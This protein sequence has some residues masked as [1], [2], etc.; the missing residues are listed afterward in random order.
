MSG[1]IVA[2]DAPVGSGTLNA[3]A[4]QIMFPDGEPDNKF[5]GTLS[6]IWSAA[7]G[8]DA[9]A[10]L[11][12]HNATTNGVIVW[13]DTGVTP[14]RGPW[15]WGTGVFTPS[16]RSLHFTAGHLLQSINLYRAGFLS[17]YLPTYLSICAC[18]RVCA[19]ARGCVTCVLP[20][21]GTLPPCSLLI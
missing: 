11:V 2:C 14:N 19:R 15:S 9:D 17:T 3:A 21:T 12:A 1:N 16:N 13:W 18:V 8:T 5:T 10:Y 7:N 6:G 4:D 20:G